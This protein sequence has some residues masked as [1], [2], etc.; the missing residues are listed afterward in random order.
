MA[1]TSYFAGVLIF[2]V[3]VFVELLLATIFSGST[4]EVSF[5]GFLFWIAVP[6]VLVLSQLYLWL[7][8][9]WFLSA[10]SNK[11][12]RL[13]KVSSDIWFVIVLFGFAVGALRG[14]TCHSR[15]TVALAISAN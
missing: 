9:L 6:T 14:E 15:A 10:D 7:R 2:P 11:P 1:D 13:D 4:E 3:A 8:M 12:L 5:F